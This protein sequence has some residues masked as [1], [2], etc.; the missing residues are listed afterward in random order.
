MHSF[1][2]LQKQAVEGEKWLGMAMVHDQPK[3][4]RVSACTATVDTK[5]KNSIKLTLEYV[6]PQEEFPPEILIR[7]ANVS[8][9]GNDFRILWSEKDTLILFSVTKTYVF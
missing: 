2:K 5:E 9:Y 8:E 3:S 4:H 6:R 7:K 1:H